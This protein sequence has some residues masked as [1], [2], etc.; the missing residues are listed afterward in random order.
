MKNNKLADKY[1]DEGNQNYKKK[2]FYEA[3]KSYN[4]SF[5]YAE[6]LSDR[7]SLV[8]ANRS[9]VYFEVNQF[10]NCLE[11]IKFA[12]SNGYKSE[13][14]LKEREEKCL[15]LMITQKLDPDEDPWKYF[16]LSNPQNE[17][18]PFIANCLE[19]HENKKFGRYVVTNKSLKPGDIV[20]IETPAFKVIHKEG[21]Y[22]N[23]AN[24]L[25]ENMLNLIPCN[26][27]VH[28]ECF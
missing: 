24:C 23:C 18:I 17:K 28:S 8:F 22:S 19:L 21:R 25:S 13:E 6:P 14:K 9:A 1:R 10:E 3:L 12:R 16:K 26:T 2:D 7:I 15:R 4:K 27:C 5:C 11:N 20:A